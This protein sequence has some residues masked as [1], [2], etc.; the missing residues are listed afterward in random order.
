M[1][2]THVRSPIIL[3]MFRLSNPVQTAIRRIDR[4]CS[5]NPSCFLQIRCSRLYSALVFAL[6]STQ[7]L[8]VRQTLLGKPI[9]ESGCDAQED[10]SISP[11]IARPHCA[12]NSR[13]QFN[14]PRHDPLADSRPNRLPEN[15]TTALRR[16]PRVST[17]P[18]RPIALTA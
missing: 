8:S 2:F 14:C 3:A 18:Q 16:S 17:D 7:P 6:Q 12:L 11:K 13:L 5:K 10:S 9:S 15:R 4:Q 1:L